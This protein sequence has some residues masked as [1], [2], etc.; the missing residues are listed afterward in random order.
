MEQFYTEA[1][2]D[3]VEGEEDGQNGFVRIVVDVAETVLLAVMLFLIINFVTARIQVDGFSMEPTMHSGE[4]VIVS[5]VAYDL[6]FRFGEL[7]NLSQRLSDPERGDIVV[8]NPPNNPNE[9]YIKRIIGL[10]GDEVVVSDGKVLINGEALDEPYI[11]A[12]PAYAGTWL[13]PEDSIFVLGDN[14]NNSSDS[15]NWDSVPIEDV[16]GK[17]IFIYW[18]PTEWGVVE[19]NDAQA[20]P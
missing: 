5:R 10:P 18:P 8:F 15:H 14:R 1:L 16:I 12:A 9:E 13:V 11:N 2:L 6:R 20:A 7:V 4:F 3:P 17:A 19:P